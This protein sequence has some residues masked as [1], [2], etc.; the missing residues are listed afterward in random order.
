MEETVPRKKTFDGDKADEAEIDGSTHCFICRL[1]D[2]QFEAV[3]RHQERLQ[4]ALRR[5]VSRAA[6]VREL[7]GRVL[8]RRKRVPDHRQTELV[9]FGKPLHRSPLV[10]VEAQRA[11]AGMRDREAR[12]LSLPTLAVEEQRT[13]AQAAER[14]SGS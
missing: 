5:P 13:V 6:A 9:L 14:L 1:G 3:V 11:L 12:S 2:D 7:I 4:K 10:A 8:P